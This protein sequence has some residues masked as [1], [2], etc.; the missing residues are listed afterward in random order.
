MWRWPAVLFLLIL[1]LWGVLNLLFWTPLGTGILARKLE[2]RFGFPCS[3]RQVSWTPWS[4]LNIRGLHFQAPPDL[5]ANGG[6]LEIESVKID[7]S[8][9]SLLRGKKRFEKLSVSGVNG[10]ISLELLKSLLAKSK[11]SVPHPIVSGPAETEAPETTETPDPPVVPAVPEGGSPGVPV[12]PT[13]NPPTSPPPMT[14]EAKGSEQIDD[15]VGVLSFDDVNLKF[16]SENIPQLS[17]SVTGLEGE[18]PV[19]GT[20]G[21]GE[22]T[23]GNLEVADHFDSGEIR[24]PVSFKDR[25]LRVEDFQLKLFGLDSNIEA[26]VR[27]VPGLPY[28]IQVNLP[29]QQLDLSPIYL[30]QQPPL[31]IR[32]LQFSSQVQGFITVPSSLTG[33]GF[34]VFQD[35]VLMNRKNESENGFHTGSAHFQFSPAGFL[36]KD[37]RAMGEEEAIL[38]NGFA[39][40]QGEAAGV[41]RI[42]ASPNRAEVF[43]NR[44]AAASPDL[45]FEFSPLGTPDREFRDLH[46][47]LQGGEIV[48]DLGAG[49]SWIP[50][51]PVAKSI[52][53][54]RDPQPSVFP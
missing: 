22:V 17:A 37:F 7:P 23:M 1:A 6:G 44:V 40:V 41:L 14:T 49:S 8:W 19:W 24:I 30:D 16:F 32:A 46:L 53:D 38:G 21:E 35:L 10:E 11:S 28:G 54:S 5:D 2:A 51:L 29:A 34:V 36:A 42:V 39:S 33:E 26:A 3:I 52:L 25:Y 9:S 20:G 50:A 13:V 43:E 12:T 4:G 15:F 18:F 31:A 45:S 47:E 48:V 27:L